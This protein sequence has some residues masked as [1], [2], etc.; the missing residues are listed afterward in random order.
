MGRHTDGKNAILTAWPNLGLP[1]PTQAQLY[2]AMAVACRESGYGFG[3]TGALAGSNN[4][5][6]VQAG[7]PPCVD[8]YSVQGK[9]SHPDGTLYDVCFRV[10][11]TP[12][13]GALGTLKTLY[14]NHGRATVFE[15]AKRGN[16]QAFGQAM[17]NS[18]YYEGTGATVEERVT[19]YTDV[20]WKCYQEAIRETGDPPCFNRDTDFGVPSDS[21]PDAVVSTLTGGGGVTD[22]R[23]RLIVA[24]AGGVAGATIYELYRILSQK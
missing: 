9:D 21:L 23:N 1:E 20:L 3:W 16:M 12:A 10:Y 18:G 4:W 6:A 14:I 15:A 24:A 8:G 7:L 11:A 17:F 22:L 5:G 13:E 2:G 19:G